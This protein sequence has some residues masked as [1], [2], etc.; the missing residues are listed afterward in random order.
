MPS[1]TMPVAG[2][3]QKL[4]ERLKAEHPGFWP[5]LI[6][7]GVEKDV[8]DKVMRLV[9]YSISNIQLLKQRNDLKKKWCSSSGEDLDSA[10]DAVQ[11]K[12]ND[13][14]KSA[15]RSGIKDI[16]GKI[17]HAEA[18]NSAFYAAK[19]AVHPALSTISSDAIRTIHAAVESE[20]WNA[21][22]AAGATRDVAMDFV[23]DAI[24]KVDYLISP[25]FID[26]DQHLRFVNACWEVWCM[27]FCRHSDVNGV[28][29]VYFLNS[30][31][32]S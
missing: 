4:I 32:R 29:F 30:W 14:A 3:E 24:L 25:Y 15:E 27:G 11:R 20:A 13:A 16:T 6:E 18:T 28:Q 22:R 7:A 5:M 23:R 9:F 17:V 31:L 21:A 8:S 1:Q 12:A 19:D 26:K 2:N 10:R